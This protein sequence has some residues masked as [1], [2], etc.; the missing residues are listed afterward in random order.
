M[1]AQIAFIVANLIIYWS[2]WDTLWKLGIAIV[3]GYVVIG[4]AMAFDKD[5]PALE[6]KS[7][8]WLPVYLIGMGV[9]S[10]L[11][12]FGNG[13]NDLKLPWDIVIIAVFSLAVYY[14]AMATRLSRERM[15]DYV[16]KQALP[17]AETAAETPQAA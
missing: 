7:A 1:L 10:W 17:E 6:W 13:R 14:W 12:G 16:S 8:M 4:V 9:I 5:R 2:G 15:L 11:G 3:I